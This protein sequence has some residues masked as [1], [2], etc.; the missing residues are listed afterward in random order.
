M[1]NPWIIIVYP[2]T[3]VLHKT[4]FLISTFQITSSFTSK[5]PL[6]LRGAFQRASRGTE[7]SVL[8]GP[9]F[10]TGPSPAP[11][12]RQPT[13]PAAPPPEFR[14]VPPPGQV[15]GAA[16]CNWEILRIEDMVPD[17]FMCRNSCGLI[18]SLAYS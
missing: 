7:R 18:I 4:E 10:P 2:S 16:L 11:D 17:V 12:T 9:V 13:A 8:P 1:L 15:S 14:V 6:G 3:Q 5:T